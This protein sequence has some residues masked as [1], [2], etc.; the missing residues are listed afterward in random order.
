M[1]TPLPAALCL[2]IQEHAATLSKAR[3]ADDALRALFLMHCE[4]KEA[5]ALLAAAD[6]VP[7][8]VPVLPVMEDV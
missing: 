6:P 4:C 3:T 2:R 7:D 1:N 5:C 8:P